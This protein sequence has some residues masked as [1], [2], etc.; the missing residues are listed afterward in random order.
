M[1]GR[2]PSMRFIGG[3]SD[4]RGG[5]G[6]IVGREATFFEDLSSSSEKNDFVNQLRDEVREWR[7]QQAI[8]APQ[9]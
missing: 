7:R 4:A 9:S 1:S 2:R 3:A 6:G 8:R 5:I